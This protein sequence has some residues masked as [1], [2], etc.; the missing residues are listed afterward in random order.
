MTNNSRR[1][2]NRSA[3][4]FEREKHLV[5]LLNQRRGQ[6]AHDYSDPNTA[7]GRETGVDV[8]MVSDEGRIGI[9]VTEIDTGDVQGMARADEKKAWRNSGLATY[10]ALTQND[11][12]KL[13]ASIQRAITR[14]VAIAEAHP[15][16]E[17][18][19]VWLLASAGVPEMGAV[20]S[21]LIMSPCLDAAALDAV[22]S[23]CLSRSKYERAYL[24]CILGVEHALY[25][26]KRGRG[27]TKEVQEE[28]SWMR[29]PS[30]WDVQKLMR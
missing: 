14:K 3:V 8:L 11:C 2:E 26:W 23:D 25:C 20:A 6:P 7:A 9:Q 21:T 5:A 16:G 12:N 18:N 22:T 30:F 15:F 19:A 24:H 1:T 28:P 29:G 27:W 17:F 4:R 13:L 10:V